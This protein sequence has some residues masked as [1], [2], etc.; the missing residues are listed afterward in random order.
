[1]PKFALIAYGT[2]LPTLD[3]PT[4]AASAG[5]ANEITLPVPVRYPM[6]AILPKGSHLIPLKP[7]RARFRKD[8]ALSAIHQYPVFYLAD[9]P[10]KGWVWAIHEG[11]LFA[12]RSTTFVPHSKL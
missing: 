8:F 3:D 9:G 6:N 4:C 11:K 7:H 5:Y 2:T 10:P 1:M 12:Y